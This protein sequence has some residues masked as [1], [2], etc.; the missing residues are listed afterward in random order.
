[1]ECAGRPDKY[2]I[3]GYEIVEKVVR[4]GNASSGRLN[5][6]L[7]WVGKKVKVIRVDP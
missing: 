1:M 4:P 3:T 6:P 5:M 2:E 7:A